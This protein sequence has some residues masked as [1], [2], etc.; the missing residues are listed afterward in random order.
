MNVVVLVDLLAY[1]GFVA[2]AGVVFRDEVALVRAL[3]GEA[4]PTAAPL[5]GSDSRQQLPVLHRL[6]DPPIARLD[7]AA[8]AEVL[9]SGDATTRALGGWPRCSGCCASN[10]WPRW[11]AI[12]SGRGAAPGPHRGPAGRVGGAART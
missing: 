3:L 9:E 10:G 8:D 1:S 11:I 2:A 6:L 5:D 4:A 12:C 7:A